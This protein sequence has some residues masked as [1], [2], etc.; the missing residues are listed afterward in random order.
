M[1]T[2]FLCGGSGKRMFPFTEDKF[3]FDFLGKSLLQHQIEMA[4]KAGLEHFVIIANPGNMEKIRQVTK[5]LSRTKVEFALQEKPLGIADALKSASP[6]LPGPFLVVNPNDVFSS[7]AYSK[8]ISE[9]SRLSDAQSCMLGYKVN[10]Y[11]PG[12]YLEMDSESNLK[13][14]VEKPKPGSEPSNIINILVHFHNNP[15]QLVDYIDTIETDRDDVYERA[16]D[17]MINDGYKIKVIPY[18]D[19]WAPIKYPWHILRVME[20]FLDTTEQYIAPSAHVSDRA[21]IKGKVTLCDNVKVLENAVIRGP[22]YIGPNS[23]IGN[24]ALVRD[25]C[26]IGASSVVGYSSEVKHSYIG[27]NCWFHSNYIGDSVIDN[28]CSFGSG[29]ITANLRLDEG[30]VHIKVNGDK[31]DTG[32]DKLGAIVG[33]GCRIGINANLMPGIRVGA[34]SFVGPHV[35]LTKD[36]EANKKALPL[37]QYQVLDNETELNQDKRQQLLRKL[38]G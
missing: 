12:G 6:L 38:E 21:I 11:F 31:I 29:A 19:F 17:R 1:K 14:I 4:H 2:V 24:N 28:N 5:L 3:L 25:Y 13:H 34:N 20:H 26:H 35:C 30:N 16:L 33:K 7:L 22:V 15:Q 10:E 36:L 32:Y 37:S 23:I 8:I 18:D 9:C 27:D